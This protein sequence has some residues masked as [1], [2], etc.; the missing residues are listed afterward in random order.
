[1]STLWVHYEYTSSSAVTG[2]ND[3]PSM[4]IKPSPENPTQAI[5]ADYT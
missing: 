5:L 1:M 2:C 3:S 4:I